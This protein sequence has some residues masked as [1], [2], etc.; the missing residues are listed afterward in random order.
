[1]AEPQQCEAQADVS[2]LQVLTTAGAF[3]QEAQTIPKSFWAKAF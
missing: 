2:V 1:M 3:V